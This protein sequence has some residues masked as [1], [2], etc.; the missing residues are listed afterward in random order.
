MNKKFSKTGKQK[1]LIFLLNIT[2][3]MYLRSKII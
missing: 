3:L 2:F 1:Y